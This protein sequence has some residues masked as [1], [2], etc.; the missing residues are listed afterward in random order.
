MNYLF[1]YHT[2]RLGGIEVYIKDIAIKLNDLGDTVTILLANSTGHSPKLLEELSE[3]GINVTILKKNIHW[4]LNCIKPIKLSDKTIIISFDVLSYAFS[5]VIFRKNNLVHITGIYHIDEWSFNNWP[6]MNSLSKKILSRIPGDNFFVYNE[7]AKD[8]FF[9]LLKS[10]PSLVPIG[11][12]IPLKRYIIPNNKSFNILL[13]GRVV[14]WKSFLWQSIKYL[15]NTSFNYQLH[16]IG[17]GT[18]MKDLK[19]HVKLNLDENNVCFYG[20]VSTQKMLEI[21]QKMDIAVSVGTSAVILSS[22]GL[23]TLIGIENSDREIL[24]TNGFFSNIKGYTFNEIEA[25]LE[26]S[27]FDIIENYLNYEINVKNEIINNHVLAAKKFDLNICVN[28]F[29][30]NSINSK[31][32]LNSVRYSL[33]IIVLFFINKLTPKSFQYWQRRIS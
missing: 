12:K 19:H 26:K 21:A 24:L 22:M 7:F 14:G 11:V 15:K 9:K 33:M 18:E 2:L 32:S 31:N 25:K 17:D 28:T 23:P 4:L 29:R 20:N 16:I 10:S 5:E 3:A 1:S 6:I 30:E 13:V 27:S 8:K